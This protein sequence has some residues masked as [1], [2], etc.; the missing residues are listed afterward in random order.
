MEGCVHIPVAESIL[1][2]IHWGPLGCFFLSD[3]YRYPDC[4]PLSKLV[5]M[6]TSIGTGDLALIHVVE[7]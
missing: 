2:H 3:S 5:Y 4:Y 6:A 7:L 1:V